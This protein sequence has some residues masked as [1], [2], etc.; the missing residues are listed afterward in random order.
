MLIKWVIAR[1]HTLF[2]EAYASGCHFIAPL[3]LEAVVR[4]GTLPFFS[5]FFPFI[6][7]RLVR[8]GTVFIFL[9]FFAFIFLFFFAFIFFF[10]S[11]IIFFFYFLANT[12][13]TLPMVARWGTHK[14]V[15]SLAVFRVVTFIFTCVEEVTGTLLSFA[16]LQCGTLH[17]RLLKYLNPWYGHGKVFSRILMTLPGFI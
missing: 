17:W 1:G 14:R 5:F 13:V 3:N 15:L 10:F 2:E 6:G 8:C 7:A 11:A 12:P 4:K 9:F 16:F